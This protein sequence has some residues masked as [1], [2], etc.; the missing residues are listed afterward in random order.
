VLDRDRMGKFDA[1][2]NNVYQEID[3][4]LAG[5]MFSVPS[6][7]D[8]T[9]YFGAVGDAIKAFPISGAKLSPT[10]SSRTLTTFVYPGATVSISANGLR[11]GVV[12]AVQNTSPAVLSAYDAKNLARQLYS[13]NQVPE[14]D[15]F[16]A[17]NKFVTPTIA[18]GRVYVGTPTGV[19]VFGLLPE[20]SGPPPFKRIR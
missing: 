16:G 15:Q 4:V 1:G 20:R 11:D 2:R 14:R 18:N 7:F 17:G 6:Y 8:N 13:S 3:G 19:A 10:P 9:V 12:W 5:G